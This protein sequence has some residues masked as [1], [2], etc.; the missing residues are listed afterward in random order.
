MAF[1][2]HVEPC[3]PRSHVRIWVVRARFHIHLRREDQLGILSRLFRYDRFPLVGLPALIETAAPKG[4]ASRL[5]NSDAGTKFEL[6]GVTTPRRRPL[7]V[8]REKGT[9]GDAQRARSR[10]RGL[11]AVSTL[12]SSVPDALKDG[13]LLGGEGERLTRRG[14]LAGAPTRR[15]DRANGTCC[16]N[17]R[18]VP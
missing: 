7:L 8:T 11:R 5:P 10:C 9:G 17:P 3:V 2:K 18:I 13:G 4:K 14:E 15:A 6:R 12:S 1:W 16:R